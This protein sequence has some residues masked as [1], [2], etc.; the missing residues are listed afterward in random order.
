MNLIL[1]KNE[2]HGLYWY[3]NDDVYCAICFDDLWFVFIFTWYEAH[4]SKL[5]TCFYKPLIS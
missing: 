1:F 5:L 2:F 3:N 4:N